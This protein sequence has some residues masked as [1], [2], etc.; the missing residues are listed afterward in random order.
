MLG[1]SQLIQTSTRVNQQS[2]WGLGYYQF[3]G[4]LTKFNLRRG[5]DLSNQ[6]RMNTI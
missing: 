3:T 4:S 1:K 2:F 5:R 6:T